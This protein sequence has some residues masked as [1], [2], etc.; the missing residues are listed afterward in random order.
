MKIGIVVGRFQV[1]RLHRGHMSL[2]DHAT[3]NS[4]KLLI[5][6]GCSTNPPNRREPLDF[7]T[8]QVM[9]QGHFPQAIILPQW[10]YPS[11][12]VWSANITRLVHSLFP[13]THEAVMYGGRDSCLEHFQ[14]G[15]QKEYVEN[16]DLS[17]GTVEREATAKDI[18]NSEDFRSGCIYTT[19]RTR[20]YPIM[21]VDIALI[22]QHTDGISLLLGRK[23]GEGLWRF[24]GGK[25]DITDQSLE[26][27]GRRELQEEAGIFAE[28]MEYVKS[29][30]V[31]DW[32]FGKNPD[33]KIMTTLYMGK[34]LATQVEKAG[35]DLKEVKWSKLDE[36]SPIDMVIAHRPLLLDLKEHLKKAGYNVR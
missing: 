15:F 20:P 16:I 4:D 26:A 8:R 12:E 3:I 33:Q 31:N 11:D 24:P 34:E 19:Y 1:S 18:A 10:D 32:R 25:V 36:L 9:I 14:G 30:L 22:R 17:S 35:D 13:D 27:C 2:L 23:P 21:A 7:K 29:Y 6:L 5:L 28:H